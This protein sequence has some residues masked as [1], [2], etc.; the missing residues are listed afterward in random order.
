MCHNIIIIKAEQEDFKLPATMGS[1][2]VK[3][4]NG[5]GWVVF[6][7]KRVQNIKTSPSFR[8]L[9]SFDP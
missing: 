2:F 1:T 6:V 5:S 3:I 7:I 4:G 9:P 8:T